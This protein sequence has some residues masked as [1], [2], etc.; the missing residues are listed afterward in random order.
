MMTL[1]HILYNLCKEYISQRL[2]ETEKAIKD[3]EEAIGNETKSSAGDKYE[4]SRE[5]MQQEINRD[6]ARKYELQKLKAAL[7]LIDPEQQATTVQPG[8]IVYTDSGNYYI[9]ISAGQL[10]VDGTGYYSISAVT[11]IGKKLIGLKAG[12]VFEFNG[13][14]IRVEQVA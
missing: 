9:A 12:D 3:T 2:N 7:D 14:S 5:M 1:K 11:P 13:K 8:S 6:L 4:T 10:K